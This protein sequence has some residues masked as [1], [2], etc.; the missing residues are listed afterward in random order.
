M[1]AFVHELDQNTLSY[2]YEMHENKTVVLVKWT[3]MF[4]VYDIAHE[5]GHVLG[6]GHTPDPCKL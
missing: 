3:S 4:E 6:A 5:I 1:I 2:P